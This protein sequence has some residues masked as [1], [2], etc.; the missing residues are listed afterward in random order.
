MGKKGTGVTK[1]Q[2][3][4]NSDKKN[5]DQAP[6]L[7]RLAQ[8]VESASNIAQS[9]VPQGQE[10]ELISFSLRI[11]KSLDQEIKAHFKQLP[12]RKRPNRNEFIRQAIEEKLQRDR[13]KVGKW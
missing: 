13:K 1:P 4:D 5:A 6:S 2:P 11:W 8:L 12:V 3:K 9:I 7:K 10:D